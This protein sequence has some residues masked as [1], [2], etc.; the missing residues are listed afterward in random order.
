[1][2]LTDHFNLVAKPT[3]ELHALCRELFNAL[4]RYEL[5][6]EE[7]AQCR[8]SLEQIRLALIGRGPRP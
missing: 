3:A 2:K 4:A 1:M 7:H 5:D 8:R 6:T